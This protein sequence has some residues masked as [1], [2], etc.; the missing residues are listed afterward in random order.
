MIKEFD[1]FLYILIPTLLI[2]DFL[3]LG[4]II[5]G[6]YIMTKIISKLILDN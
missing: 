4:L 2:F 1:L 5:A 3:Y 6:T